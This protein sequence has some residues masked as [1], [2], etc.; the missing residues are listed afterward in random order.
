MLRK[1][2]FFRKNSPIV[3]LSPFKKHSLWS[4][5]TDRVWEA[6]RKRAHTQLVREHSVTV[7]SAR[8]A[9][10]DWSWPFRVESVCASWSPL[11]KKK[12]KKR[13]R[14]KNC[15]TFAP[16]PRTRGKCHHYHSKLLCVLQHITRRSACSRLS[17]PRGMYNDARSEREKSRLAID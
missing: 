2:H 3:L 9:T 5:W 12:K 8:W 6:I 17:S 14:G 16:K 1:R 13:R 15:Q 7:V 11:Q 4:T 10:R